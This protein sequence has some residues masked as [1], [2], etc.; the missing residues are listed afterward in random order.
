MDASLNKILLI[1]KNEIGLD[2]KTIGDATIEKIIQQRMHQCKINSYE[3]Y[4]SL[5]NSTSSELY[6]LLEM[7]VIPETWF[8][9]DIRPFEFIYTKIQKEL[10]KNKS[11]FFKI[12]SI[13]CSTGEEPY[14]LAMYL[15]SKGIPESSFIIDAVDISKRSLQIAEQGAYGN[16][17]FRG[18]HYHEFQLKY[19]NKEQDNYQIKHNIQQKINFYI[20]NI[21]QKITEHKY[22]FDF[23]LCRNLLIYFDVNT[24]LIAFKQ[25][26]QL[27]NKNGYL[28]IGHSEFGSVP[29]NTFQN[30]GFEQAFA[31]IKHNHPAFNSHNLVPANSTLPCEHAETEKHHPPLEQKVNFESL[32]NKIKPEDKISDSLSLKRI[33][34]IAN[35]AELSEAE[36][37]CH[38]HIKQYGENSEALFLLGL[39]ASS[40][41]K[42]QSAESFFR[43][44]LFLEPKHYESLVHLS[45]LLQENGDLKNASLFKKRAEKALTK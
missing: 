42:T 38:E 23:I 39:I 28:F 6:E 24:K 44:C 36:S 37:L 22:E 30:M 18:K 45:L 4:H 1:V 12:M 41:K 34:E 3:K 2:S 19:F 35:S 17:S 21:L 5:L 7:V 33:R 10:I 40:Q 29:E 27:L 13:P 32:I 31:L 16:N 8:F 15:I 25:L 26:S 14:S 9:R 43:K 20:F 11:R